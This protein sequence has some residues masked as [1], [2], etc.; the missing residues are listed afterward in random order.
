MTTILDAIRN[1]DAA[2]ARG[3]IDETEF[4]D[5]RKAVMS[6]IE[7]AEVIE[8][9][10]TDMVVEPTKAEEPEENEPRPIE[11]RDLWLFRA[12]LLVCLIIALSWVFAD[13]TVA[14]TLATAGLAV[15]V[16][17]AAQIAEEPDSIDVESE[18]DGDAKPIDGA[19]AHTETEAQSQVEARA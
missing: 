13:E 3:E 19:D 11:A 17:R 10:I 5:V 16:I 15:V 8:P 18:P 1:L 12:G 6:L 4:R 14:F 7:D 2:R 9:D